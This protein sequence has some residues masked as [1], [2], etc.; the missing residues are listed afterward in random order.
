MSAEA[1]ARRR[2]QK[3]DKLRNAVLAPK[4]DMPPVVCRCSHARLL[5][6]PKCLHKPCGCAEYRERTEEDG[7]CRD[8]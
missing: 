4:V 6:Q 7:C 8:S 1:A 2:R 3:A 5:H